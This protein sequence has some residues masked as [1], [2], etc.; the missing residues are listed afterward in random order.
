[1]SCVCFIST[2]CS[3]ILTV[4]YCSIVFLCNFVFVFLCTVTCCVSCIYW[5][6]SGIINDDDN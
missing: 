6:P 5:L 1:M 2:F 4:L 3:D